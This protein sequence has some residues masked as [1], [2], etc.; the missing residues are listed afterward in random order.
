MNIDPTA[1][2]AARPGSNPSVKSAV[3]AKL[4]LQLARSADTEHSH[5]K[6]RRQL[7][8][9]YLKCCA[10]KGMA[11]G[12]GRRAPWT[13]AVITILGVGL[14]LHGTRYF[15]E[16]AAT[17]SDPP[18]SHRPATSSRQY[19]LAPS[20]GG[21]TR[22]AGVQGVAKVARTTGGTRGTAAHTVASADPLPSLTIF[23]VLSPIGTEPPPKDPKVKVQTHRVKE[24]IDKHLV[25]AV[26]VMSWLDVDPAAQL[27]LFGTEDTCAAFLELPE[28][29]RAGPARVTCSKLRCFREGAPRLDCVF[30]DAVAASTS[31]VLMY[32]N[33]DV[34]VF[35]DI[36]R[37]I[38]HVKARAANFFVVAKRFDLNITRALRA[39]LRSAA[40]EGG[41]PLDSNAAATGWLQHLT[42]DVRGSAVS[43]A[44]EG[45]DIMAFPR[46]TPPRVP[47]FLVGRVQWDN[48]M[49]LQAIS[50]PTVLSVEVSSVALV[51]HLNHGQYKASAR[52]NGTRYNKRLAVYLPHPHVKETKVYHPGTIW[53]GRLDEVD[54]NL[55]PADAQWRERSGAYFSPLASLPAG[56]CPDCVLVRNDQSPDLGLYLAHGMV[57]NR[58]TVVLVRVAER[59]LRQALVHHCVAASHDVH[60]VLF[61]TSEAST[62]GVLRVNGLNSVYLPRDPTSELGDPIVRVFSFVGKAL[63]DGYNVLLASPRHILT[64]SIETMVDTTIDIAYPAEGAK[65]VF[66]YLRSRGRTFQFANAMAEVLKADLRAGHV[67]P[68]S[69]R[70]QELI[71]A[72][73]QR[74]KD[75]TVKNAP[76]IGHMATAAG[77][78][79]YEAPHIDAALDSVGTQWVPR[80]APNCT[81]ARQL[82][83]KRRK[84]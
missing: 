63:Y 77:R 10:A 73:F 75:A 22:G 35:S 8:R 53:L 65:T 14:W 79:V 7:S 52:K 34:V 39:T 13:A 56:R 67:A 78:S 80:D 28:L 2:A 25:Q 43:H 60:N 33:A 38:A 45:I 62:H 26:A 1:R 30:G 12:G 16:T 68:Y 9:G 5:S 44:R 69:W 36:L 54:A 37:A 3:R 46:A 55:V 81:A 83:A 66:L 19:E 72:A 18:S 71:E 21:G 64:A 6:L 57:H 50:M 41:T 4:A 40:L 48:W 61:L 74:V 51:V 70:E 82:Y 58:R 27:L 76:K 31:D 59:D 24:W 49:L 29:K 32:A 17:G 42:A 47:P 11:L 84:S 15:T 20:P 23:T